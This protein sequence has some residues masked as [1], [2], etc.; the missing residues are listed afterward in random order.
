MVPFPSK[1][2]STVCAAQNK[3][4]DKKK[5]YKKNLIAFY[6]FEIQRKYL[7]GWETKF[8]PIHKQYTLEKKSNPKATKHFKNN[9]CF[10][11]K[12][13]CHFIVSIRT[14]LTTTFTARTSS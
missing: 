13:I 5:E 3:L 10:L 7:L 12:S 11:F 1:L 14:M 8:R 6:K 9:R 2:S 4:I